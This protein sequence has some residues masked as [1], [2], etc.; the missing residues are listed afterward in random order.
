[1]KRKETKMLEFG[2]YL[3]R[4]FREDGCKLFVKGYSDRMEVIFSMPL[5]ENRPD[6]IEELEQLIDKYFKET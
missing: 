6:F 4:T 3:R 2:S 5:T 1:M